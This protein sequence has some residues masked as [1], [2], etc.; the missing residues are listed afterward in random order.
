MCVLLARIFQFFNLH[1]QRLRT[2]PQLSPLLNV[3]EHE[4]KE[5]NWTEYSCKKITNL[6][7]T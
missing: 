6:I 4:P 7:Q 3:T 1:T 2:Y 5:R